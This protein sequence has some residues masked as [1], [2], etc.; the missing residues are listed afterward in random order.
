MSSWKSSVCVCVCVCVRAHVCVSVCVYACM[1]T[2]CIIEG[3]IFHEFHKCLIRKNFTI[4]APNS[5][6]PL[7]SSQ[8]LNS[9]RFSSSKSNPLYSMHKCVHIQTQCVCVCACA[10]APVCAPVWVRLCECIH[11]STYIC[12]QMNLRII[13][14]VKI[15]C[16]IGTFNKHCS[17]DISTMHS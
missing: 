5:P 13:E 10:C 15:Y 9:W 17:L 8:W 4:S 6:E 7:K 11:T 3:K 14:Y 1:C 2:N 12:T 16:R